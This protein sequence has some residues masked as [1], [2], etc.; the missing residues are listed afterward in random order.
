[1]VVRILQCG[2]DCVQFYDKTDPRPAKRTLKTKKKRVASPEPSGSCITGPVLSC[3]STDKTMYVTE[4]PDD[5][6][7]VL[8]PTTLSQQNVI[9]G[10]AIN[11]PL[12]V[13]VVGK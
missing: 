1:M 8:D 5:R 7:L 13:N 3:G 12:S 11:A 6:V 9:S 4:W 10:S 2:H